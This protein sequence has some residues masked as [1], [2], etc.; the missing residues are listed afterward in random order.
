MSEEHT[1]IAGCI[2]WTHGL[3]F[4]L[5]EP[6]SE[7]Q[8]VWRHNLRA[9]SIAF[10]LWHMARWAD[11]FQAH[12][13][14][15]APELGQRLGSGREM[16]EADGM[17]ERWGVGGI[18]LGHYDSGMNMG[19]EASTSFP[20]PGKATL[21]DYA[22]RAFAAADRAADAADRETFEKPCIDLYGEEMRVGDVFAGYLAHLNRHLGMIESLV[23][24]QG[25]P[26]TATV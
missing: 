5:V 15:M 6:L 2:H 7:E 23:G 21:M 14:R 26:G 1:W 11:R 20:L 22:Q 19:D 4:K 25:M 13:P 12:L 16:W 3:V 10:H 24:M 18:E 9:P 17:A 8:L